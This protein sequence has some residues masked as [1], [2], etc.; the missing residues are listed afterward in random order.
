MEGS[1]P[2]DI[3]FSDAYDELKSITEELNGSDTVPPERLLELL[4]RGKGLEQVLRQHLDD[5]E[6]QVRS[7]EAGDG[8]VRY[9]IVTGA[10]R[11]N[12]DLLVSNDEEPSSATAPSLA[13]TIPVD[14]SD[15]VPSSARDL[16]GD[17]IPF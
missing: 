14:A 16:K 12:D 3:T 8:L 10:T 13:Q 4:R 5:V 17:D 15:F 9:R 6:Q 1:T 11:T 2:T 7:I